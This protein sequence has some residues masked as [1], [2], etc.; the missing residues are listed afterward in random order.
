M[1]Y[2]SAETYDGTAV[3]NQLDVSVESWA[4]AD[5][6]TLISQVDSG[7]LDTNLLYDNT[8]VGAID[9]D[10]NDLYV[11]VDTNKAAG[12]SEVQYMQWVLDASISAS[13]IHVL[14]ELSV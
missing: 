1:G 4:I 5:I 8:F 11:F 9:A 6:L 13:D 3:L 10:N 2:S 14:N 12:V 7:A